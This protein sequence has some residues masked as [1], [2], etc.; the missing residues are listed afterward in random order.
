MGSRAP[1]R[2]VTRALAEMQTTILAKGLLL[3]NGDVGRFAIFSLIVRMTTA[4]PEHPSAPNGITVSSL[5]GSLSLPYET[6][7]RHVGFLI[8]D[9]LC[10]R[11]SGGV[12]ANPGS[13]ADAVGEVW[14]TAHDALG[15][16]V[17]RLVEGSVRVPSRR[18]GVLYDPAYGVL[19]AVDLMLSVVDGNRGTHADLTQLAIFSAIFSR[20]QASIL[21]DP[22]VSST[23]R[24]ETRPVPSELRSNVRAA[25]I[26][27]MLPISETTIRRHIG[28]MM[29]DGRIERCSTGIQVSERWLNEPRC[30]DVSRKS[31]ANMRRILEQLASKGFPFG[32]PSWSVLT[33]V[34]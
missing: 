17:E 6:V 25:N 1:I 9:G 2:V 26:A 13:A 11:D 20:E 32:H 3:T 4:R 30:V 19:A 23:Y 15:R 14:R 21:A 27:A 31:Y 8:S 5:A 33:N 12:S 7:R 22:A 10:S 29:A 18:P 16:F 24:D 28:Y 34:L